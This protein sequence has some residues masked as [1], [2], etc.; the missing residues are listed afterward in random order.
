MG[1]LILL[2]VARQKRQQL[3]QESQDKE[4][5]TV[6][7]ELLFLADEAWTWRDPESLAALRSCLEQI[8]VF[9]RQ[10]WGT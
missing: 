6:W 4:L 3:L 8:D 2:D 9:V 7:E 10:D 5:D 1:N